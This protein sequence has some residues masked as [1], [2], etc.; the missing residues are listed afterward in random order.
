MR[1]LLA[2]ALGAAS[3]AGPARGQAGLEAAGG[4]TSLLSTDFSAL[5][6]EVK[7]TKLTLLLASGRFGQPESW[8]NN[9]TAGLSA[10]DGER[11]LF[12]NGRWAPGLE[13][14]NRL[15]Y[16][17][18][19]A[20][21]DGDGEGYTGVFASVGY[22]VD[23][24]ALA[25]TVDGSRIE[26]YER[27]GQTGTLGLGYNWS[28]REAGPVLGLSATAGWGFNVPVARRPSQVCVQQAS[29]VD[30]DG[31]PVLISSCQSRYVGEVH[32]LRT[33]EFRADLR[34]RNFVLPLGRGT[35]EARTLTRAIDDALKLSG[36]Q[37]FASRSAAIADEEKKAI[38]IIRPLEEAAGV[39]CDALKTR[40]AA[41]TLTEAEA[42]LKTA[43]DRLAFVRGL[44]DKLTAAQTLT[45]DR[46]QISL[47]AA[48]STQ[49]AQ[50]AKPIHSVA[51]GPMLHPSLT[52]LKVVAGLLFEL[53]DLTNATGEAPD[54]EDRF[55]I[56]LYV[57]VPF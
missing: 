34:S 22:E 26:T 17:W 18:N 11:A 57:G 2:A 51:A 39:T 38:V 56:R 8:Q 44:R 52:P 15:A 6:V 23:G 45:S 3:A 42:R 27:T 41:Q 48:A 19:R 25:R 29:G 31:A 20:N 5:T 55:A 46:P 43:C 13:L 7:D 35:N 28:P 53:D 49:V 33:G 40:P 50:G 1:L 24:N 54:W 9:F 16:F 30:K 47:L 32:D 10:E 14:E 37:S 36:R 21:F 12:S 4:T